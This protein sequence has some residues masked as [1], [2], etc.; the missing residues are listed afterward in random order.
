MG[1]PRLR[2]FAGPNGS[3]KTTLIHSI[4]EIVPL[5]CYINADDILHQLNTHSYL[6]FANYLPAP[7]SHEKWTAFI[8]AQ[9]D[10]SRF[11]K[12][13]LES[14][15]IEDVFLVKRDTSGLNSYTAA[16]I[17]EFFREQLLKAKKSFSFETVMSHPSKVSFIRKSVSNDF[18][19]YLY[20]VCTSDVQ[21]NSKRVLNR[22][23]KGGHPVDEKKIEQ[24]YY[25][26]LELLR[27]ALLSVDRAFVIDSSGAD[28]NLVLEK[29]GRNIKILHDTVPGWVYEYLLEKLPI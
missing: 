19:T 26:S 17:A 1:K 14:L 9:R 23:Q 28:R 16:L 15:F 22:V 20:F 10:N 25:R 27:D 5:G 13:E 6:S 18:K 7:V 4:K 11:N 12:L 29:N 24:R 2:I 8:K 3:G 21:I